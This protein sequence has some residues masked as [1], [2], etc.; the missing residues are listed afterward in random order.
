MPA[1]VI[2]LAWITYP[3]MNYKDILGG[4][5]DFPDCTVLQYDPIIGQLKPTNETIE[6]A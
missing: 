2:W 6:V 3:I 4:V 1:L 5:H